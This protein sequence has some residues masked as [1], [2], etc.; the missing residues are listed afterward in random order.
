[1]FMD[2]SLADPKLAGDTSVRSALGHELENLALAGR[3][4]TQG[5]LDSPRG[6]ELGDQPGSMTEPPSA[7]RSSVSRKSPISVTRLFNR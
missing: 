7:I 6:D 1:M 5:V 4:V 3:E 2:G